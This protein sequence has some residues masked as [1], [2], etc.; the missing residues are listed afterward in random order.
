MFGCMFDWPKSTFNTQK[1]YLK[2]KNTCLVKKFENAFNNKNN[3]KMT[4]THFLQ[5]LKNEVFIKK[6]FLT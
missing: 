6:R 1:V 3:L 2:K 4:K 5:K